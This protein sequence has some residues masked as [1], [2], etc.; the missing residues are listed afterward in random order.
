MNFSE[1][2]SCEFYWLSKDLGFT[3]DS[4]AWFKSNFGEKEG[5]TKKTL[6]SQIFV[7]SRA[8]LSVSEKDWILEKSSINNDILSVFL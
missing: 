6:I 1:E 2:L 3:A 4:K 5:A 7:W 8:S